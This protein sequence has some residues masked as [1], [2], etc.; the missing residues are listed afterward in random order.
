MKYTIH[1]LLISLAFLCACSSGKTLEPQKELGTI[2][3][4]AA[5]GPFVAQLDVNREGPLARFDLDL[6]IKEALPGEL[7]IQLILPEGAELTTGLLSE[8]M[9]EPAPSL[10][11]LKRSYTLEGPAEGFTI[12]IISRSAHGASQT[13]LTWPA[14]ELTDP[15]APIEKAI[16]PITV[17]G[18]KIDKA[19]PLTPE[20]K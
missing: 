16:T 2:I 8:R 9:A 14:V 11:Q 7:E 13:R 4:S 5:R 10:R 1:A 18:I 15:V 3:H 6:K 17:H 20:G 12:L 19:I